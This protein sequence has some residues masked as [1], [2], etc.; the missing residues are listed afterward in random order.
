MA[1]TFSVGGIDGRGAGDGAASVRARNTSVPT[2]HAA[3][4]TARQRT[5]VESSMSVDAR[6]AASPPRA[7]P[8]VAPFAIRVTADFAV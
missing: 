2:K 7:P 8:R 5:V 3:L 6:H 4:K 1:E